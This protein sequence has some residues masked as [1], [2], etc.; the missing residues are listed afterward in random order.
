MSRTR[1]EL[2]ERFQRY[3]LEYP[4][5]GPALDLRRMNSPDEFIPAMKPRLQKA[6]SEMAEP[7]CGTIANADGKLM[8]GHYWF[9]LAR[10]VS[11]LGRTLAVTTEMGNGIMEAQVS[12]FAMGALIAR[13]EPSVGLYAS[14]VN[15]NAYHQPP[16][17]G[18]K[19]SSN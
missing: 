3:Y 15:V 11:E 7:E 8:V 6:F 1:V 9:W 19:W 17:G 2:W 16:V 13:F 18:R 5:I 12:P 4:E 10:I 14:F